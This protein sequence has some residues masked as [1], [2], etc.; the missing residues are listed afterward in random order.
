MDVDSLVKLRDLTA[1]ETRGGGPRRQGEVGEVGEVEVGI[2]GEFGGEEVSGL[3][4]VTL[5][6]ASCCLK[7]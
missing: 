1:A 6:F 2:R 5:S 3:T 7:I 4:F